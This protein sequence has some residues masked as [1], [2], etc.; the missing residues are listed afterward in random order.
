M[1]WGAGWEMSIE[2]RLR[3]GGAGAA[4]QFDSGALLFL[5]LNWAVS[6]F[7]FV[8]ILTY[9]HIGEC[10]PE[11]EAHR[12]LFVSADLFRRQLKWL[13]DHSYRSLS[14]DDL[15]SHLREG[16]ALP[17]RWVT[18]TFDDGW[19]DNFTQAWPLLKEFGYD[20]TV[21]LI[22]DKVARI[23]P[24]GAWDDYLTL[25]DLK[26]MHAE[27]AHFGSH[28]HTHPRL[29]KLESDDV[30]V[31]LLES[32]RRLQEDLNLPADWFCYPYGNFSPRIAGLAKDAGYVGALSTIRDN[33]PQADQLYWLPRV[34]VMNDTKPGR[35][36]YML[37]PWYHYV[38]T[39]KNR[40]RWKSIR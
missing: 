1:A 30:A 10:P 25:D 26:T 9:H 31:E 39:W 28:S 20:A 19:R 24:R 6:A 32:R 27:G 23:A 3:C 2:I 34:M 4:A 21:F 36:G 11:Q 5:E 14:L 15:A 33:K 13:R 38:H 7:G 16:R 17:R 35:L 37:S 29:T 18:I 8:A 22:T 12:G 40:R